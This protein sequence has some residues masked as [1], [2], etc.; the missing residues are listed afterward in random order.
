MSYK[1]RVIRRGWIPALVF[2]ALLLQAAAVQNPTRPELLLQRAM[3]KE[4][5]DGDPKAAIELYKQVADGKD[6]A[7]AAKALLRMAELYHKTGDEQSRKIYQR[8]V[9]DYADQKDA[10][11]LAKAALGENGMTAGMNAKL[12]YT[13]GPLLS[14]LAAVFPDGR[15]LFTSDYDAQ[16]GVYWLIH[17]VATGMER[18]IRVTDHDTAWSPAVSKD[19]KQ[20]VYNTAD[21][22]SCCEVRLGALSGDANP[23]RL[24]RNPDIEW[25]DALDWSPDGRSVAA[26]ATHKDGARQLALISVPDGSFRVLKTLDWRRVENMF[27]SPDGRWLGFDLP[28][29]ADK[30]DRDVFVLAVDGS[31]ELH[32]VDH[33]GDDEMVGWS[34]DGKWL[35]FSSDRSGT[36]D[37]LAAPFGE[38]GSVGLPQVVKTSIGHSKSLGVTRSGALYYAQD[39][40]GR[41]SRTIQIASVDIDKGKV[42]PVQFSQSPR[43]DN[44]NPRWSPDGKLLA[45]LSKRPEGSVLVIR[46]NQTG[47]PREL[48]PKLDLLSLDSWA[49]GGGSLLVTGRDSKGRYGIHLVDAETGDV[50]PIAPTAGGVFV[51]I[52][53]APDGRSL[54]FE[55]HDHG[56]GPAVYRAD[57]ESGN[58]SE[59]MPI[60]AQSNSQLRP[61]WSLGGT[62]FYYFRSLGAPCCRPA[63]LI[64]RVFSSGAERELAQALPTSPLNTK[65]LLTPDGQYILVHHGDQAAR[66]L[67]LVP[68]AGG[69]PR[70]IMSVPSGKGPGPGGMDLAPLWLAPD[71]GSALVAKLVIC[72]QDQDKC[73]HIT[74]TIS[75]SEIWLVPLR[76][77]EP[78]K[79]ER[80]VHSPSTGNRLDI[81][82][83]EM[84]VSPDGRHLAYTSD[85]NF[86]GS[87]DS[88]VW[89]L[90]NF[91]P[92][93]T[94]K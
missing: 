7:L 94:K 30:P 31:R 5:V 3:Q 75:E 37:L 36:T 20:V 85:D 21:D 78:Q 24:Y 80:F 91:L 14:S 39:K 38:N 92:K 65:P 35:L 81:V 84:A 9:N 53:W 61:I 58:V 25:F 68:F 22:P 48:K 44:V 82:F 4:T 12:V 15:H 59:V 51:N 90:E 29:A 50:K 1:Q 72:V 71:G 6:R 86:S 54:L 83:G 2:G 76:G 70:D 46:S 11:A 13:R 49:P 64:E 32:A 67:R 73:P 28:E 23:R 57:V 18:R 66:T 40:G 41:T 52:S 33:R 79:I 60:P 26:Q 93:S 62:S 77:G 42:T 45:Y 63:A 87:N 8:V 56:F 43:H 88:E 19:G 10:V 47:Q 74:S 55:T 34:S 27:F 17:E 69:N 16:L 89:A